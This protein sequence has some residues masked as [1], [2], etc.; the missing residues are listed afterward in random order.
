MTSQ[1]SP[2]DNPV[3]VAWMD[4]L[5][6]ARNLI[7][8]LEEDGVPP[9]T[10][11]LDGNTEES[12]SGFRTERKVFSKTAKRILGY[13]S[14]GALAGI[15]LGVVGA[16][17]VAVGSAVAAMLGAVFGFAV[18]GT[19]GGLSVLKYNSPAWA[20]TYETVADG[21]VRVTVTAPDAELVQRAAVLMD[22][23]DD[24]RRVDADL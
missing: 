22:A 17:S 10:I 2:V 16:G 5:D 23:A 9:R 18:G 12:E 3:A 1:H 24:V 19:I 8:T 20:Q 15:L 21:P 7:E 4:S 14:V 13:G 6:A 11:D